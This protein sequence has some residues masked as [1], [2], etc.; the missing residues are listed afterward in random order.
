MSKKIIL[1]TTSPSRIKAFDMLGVSFEA[2]GSEVN[3]YFEGRS[4]KPDELVLQLAKLKAEAVADKG[5]RY[6]TVIGFD[7]VGYFG[8]KILEKPKSWREAFDRLMAMSGGCFQFYTGI[9][10]I[11]IPWEG[12]RKSYAKVVVTNV[13][14]RNFIDPEVVHYLG[15]DENFKTYALGFDPLETYGSTFIES[16]K[17]SYNNVLRGIPLEVIVEMIMDMGDD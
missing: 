13:K 12:Q 4:E 11:D 17:G 8:G 15:Q 5:R 10:A 1:A 9:Y 14:M 16:I 7:S 6:A 3:E 2:I